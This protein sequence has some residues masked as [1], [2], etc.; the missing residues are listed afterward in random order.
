MRVLL[1]HNADYTLLFEAEKRMMILH[2][3]ARDGDLETL[4]IH[5]EKRLSG[6][7]LDLVNSAGQTAQEILDARLLEPSSGILEAWNDLL[8]RIDADDASSSSRSLASIDMY[9]DALEQP[10]PWA[11]ER[12]FTS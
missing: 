12:H 3:L 5:A 2:L 6:I 1:D 4:W 11:V 9:E 8:A 10:D 7:D